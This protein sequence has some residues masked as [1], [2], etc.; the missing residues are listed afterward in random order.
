M[1]NI[2]VE[3]VNLDE[4]GVGEIVVKGDTVIS[5]D[6]IHFT[7]DLGRLIKGKLHSTLNTFPF[8]PETV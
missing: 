5:E 7:G 3:Y 2:E 4:N 6:H 8:S 1:K